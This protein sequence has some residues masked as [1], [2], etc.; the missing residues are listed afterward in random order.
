[1][2]KE[3]FKITMGIVLRKIRKENKLTL[4]E[5]GDYMGITKSYLCDIENAKRTPR[6][7]VLFDI[8]ASYEI[9]FYLFFLRVYLES[10]RKEV[11]QSQINIFP[12][13]MTRVQKLVGTYFA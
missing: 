4:L 10:R 5:V 12:E 8:L 1:M 3:E 7:D 2:K 9:S 11:S 6:I 13:I